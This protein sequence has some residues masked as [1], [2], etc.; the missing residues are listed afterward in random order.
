MDVLVR[1][2]LYTDSTSTARVVAERSAGIA[3]I[4][5]GDVGDAFYA[6]GGGQ[7]EIVVGKSLAPRSAIADEDA[8]PAP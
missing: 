3:V 1:K 5:E 4:E 7:F 8:A 6:V 2:A